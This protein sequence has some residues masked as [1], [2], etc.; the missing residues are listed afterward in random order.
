MNIIPFHSS[1]SSVVEGGSLITSMEFVGWLL[2]AM[3]F[4]SI[5]LSSNPREKLWQYVKAIKFLLYWIITYLVSIYKLFFCSYVFHYSNTIPSSSLYQT[6]KKT[7]PIEQSFAIL[8]QALLFSDNEILIIKEDIESLKNLTKHFITNTQRIS[9]RD[10]TEIAT[11]K[12]SQKTTDNEIVMLRAQID[13]LKQFIT[14]SQKGFLSSLSSNVAFLEDMIRYEWILKEAYCNATHIPG[15]VMARM[16]ELCF[17]NND[18]CYRT[19]I[20]GHSGFSHDWNCWITH[21]SEQDIMNVMQAISKRE[22][23]YNFVFPI[24][25]LYLN[26]KKTEATNVYSYQIQELKKK[27]EMWFVNWPTNMGN[28]PGKCKTF[29]EGYFQR[30]ENVLTKIHKMG[31]I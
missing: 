18:D 29:A 11:L 22:E 7:S 31:M 8:K 26:N 2:M 25:G 19:Y 6:I 4:G 23:Y 3:V 28:L 13:S 16:V 17:I 27:T 24:V 10:S 1:A 21:A 15:T 20:R 5:V 30:V 12:Q 14:E 9:T